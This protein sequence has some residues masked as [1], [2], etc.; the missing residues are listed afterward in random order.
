[1]DMYLRSCPDWGDCFGHG[2][3][4]HGVVQSNASQSCAA[5]AFLV[6]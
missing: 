3:G 6:L 4:L 2:T 1:M 5:D